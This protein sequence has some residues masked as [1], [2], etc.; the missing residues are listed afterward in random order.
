MTES[1]VTA[2]WAREVES[3]LSPYMIYVV[4]TFLAH[5]LAWVAF[6]APYMLADR[7]GWWAKHKITRRK[8]QCRAVL[9]GCTVAPCLIVQV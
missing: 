4:G 6:N 1:D 3:R 2:W 8:V 9:S 5:E 7:Y